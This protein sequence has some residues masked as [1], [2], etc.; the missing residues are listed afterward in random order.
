MDLHCFVDPMASDPI[1]TTD[2]APATTQSHVAAYGCSEDDRQTPRHAHHRDDLDWQ[3]L[4]DPALRM[5]LLA[6]A[7][8][9][10][11]VSPDL[12]TFWDTSSIDPRYSSILRTGLPPTDA[13]DGPAAQLPPSLMDLPKLC[14][15]AAGGNVQQTKAAVLAWNILY[16]ALHLL[17]SI[18]DDDRPDGPWAQWG[19]GPAI[20]ITT[21][22]LIS[23][24]QALETLEDDGVPAQTARSIRR[25][26][27]QTILTMCSAQHDDLTLH[28]PTL[29]QCRQIADAKSGAFFAL[30]CRVGA[31]LAGADQQAIERFA[32]FGR[33]LG[34]IIQIGDDISGLW[35]T[36]A[37]NS[38]FHAGERWTLPI[39]YAMQMCS[40]ADR[41]L[42]QH[43]IQR[44]PIDSTAEQLARALIIETGAVLY[45]VREARRHYQRAEAILRE[46]GIVPA[47]RETLQTMLSG[48]LLK[49]SA[50]TLHDHAASPVTLS[51]TA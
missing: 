10:R 46:V 21:G 20:N 7:P 43:Y 47:A 19:V 51:K 31:Q 45:L 38:D 35:S 15:L 18:E 8:E 50:D 29:E 36:E 41:A 26:F 42:L 37:D 14:C 11:S 2:A 6:W 40:D 27:N 32:E 49:H 44:A 30:A 28:Q 34:M 16:A 17:D 13:A 5:E 48:C 9:R 4:S 39:A 25:A 23:S 24:S 22:L 33:H 12:D 3:H 1:L